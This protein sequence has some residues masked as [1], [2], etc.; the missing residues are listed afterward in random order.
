[1]GGR[2]AEEPTALGKQGPSRGKEDVKPSVWAPY[3]INATKALAV[4]F[5]RRLVGIIF[6]V[7][8]SS[9]TSSC[10]EHSQEVY[11]INRVCYSALLL[12]FR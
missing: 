8:S 2:S 3:K 9:T 5:G 4:V 11:R 10:T 7:R 1:M 6:D 12:S